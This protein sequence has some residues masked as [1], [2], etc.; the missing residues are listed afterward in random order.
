M[1][2][3]RRYFTSRH[4]LQTSLDGFLD[5]TTIAGHAIGQARE[6]FPRRAAGLSWPVSSLAAGEAGGG[7]FSWHAA[8]GVRGRRPSRGRRDGEGL[9]PAGRAPGAGGCA[10]DPAGSVRRQPGASSAPG[11]RGAVSRRAEFSPNRRALPVRG[12]R[13]HAGARDRAGGGGDAR[14]AAPFPALPVRMLVRL[15]G[16]LARQHAPSVAAADR[17]PYRFTAAGRDF[18]LPPAAGTGP[19]CRRRCRAFPPRTGRA[20]SRSPRWPSRSPPATAS[21]RIRT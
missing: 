2:F 10:Q 11:A 8:R 3:R 12:E 20:R 21:G 14:A 15:A 17:F 6:R 13:G 1:V 5:S 4:Q 16:P 19:R 7:A 18:R 9:A